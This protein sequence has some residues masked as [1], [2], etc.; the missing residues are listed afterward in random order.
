MKKN[1]KS[2]NQVHEILFSIEDI[3]ATMII[4]TN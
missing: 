1:T 4:D 3:K 2:K